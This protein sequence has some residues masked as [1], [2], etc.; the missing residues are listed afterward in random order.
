MIYFIFA[1]PKRRGTKEGDGSMKILV[2]LRNSPAYSYLFMVTTKATAD[3]IHDHV[4]DGRHS[5]AIDTVFEKGVFER[6][7][8]EVEIPATKA[9][10][11]LSERNAKWD[12]T[13]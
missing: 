7:V 1:K 9:R 3:E 4:R 6:E 2:V 8:A 13:R 10:L 5:K 12:L 11:I